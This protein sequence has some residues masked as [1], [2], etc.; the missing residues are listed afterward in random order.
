MTDSSRND[1]RN[2]D[3]THS[4]CYSNATDNHLNASFI[5]FSKLFLLGLAVSPLVAAHGKVAVIT[6][7][8]GGNTTGLAIRGGVVP[9]AGA[10]DK[11]SGGAWH[12]SCVQESGIAC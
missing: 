1:S 4:L 5:M 6:G 2:N 10:N 11:V 9:G 8:A 12:N 3:I 7:D